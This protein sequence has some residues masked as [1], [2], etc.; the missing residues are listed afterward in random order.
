MRKER[1][2]INSETGNEGVVDG[3][4]HFG[5][6]S[7]GPSLP[8]CALSYPS[9]IGAPP[10]ER[11]NAASA[12]AVWLWIRRG[13]VRMQPRISLFLVPPP[14]AAHPHPRQKKGH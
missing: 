3:K 9:T 8:Y 13:T 10:R 2:G 11:T 7:G 6:G 1:R 14:R 4:R 5:R 12:P